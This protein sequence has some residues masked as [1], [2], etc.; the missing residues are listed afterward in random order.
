MTYKKCPLPGSGHGGHPDAS[1]EYKNCKEKAE[2]LKAVNERANLQAHQRAQ[3]QQ[4]A[5][6][7]EIAK[8]QY[9]DRLLGPQDTGTDELNDPARPATPTLEGFTAQESIAE[10]LAKLAYRPPSSRPDT[11]DYEM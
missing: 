11:P 2:R 6:D 3:A 7:D 10:K 4:L 5:T 1:T 8:Q 9:F